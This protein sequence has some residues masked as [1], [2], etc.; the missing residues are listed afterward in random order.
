MQTIPITDGNNKMVNMVQAIL[1]YD[2]QFGKPSEGSDKRRVAYNAIVKQ[3]R[4]LNILE[5]AIDKE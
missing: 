4:E 1:A 3:A 2:K 5:K